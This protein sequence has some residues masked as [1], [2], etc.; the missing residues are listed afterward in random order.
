MINCIAV[1]FDITTLDYIT[2]LCS[3]IQFISLQ[4]TFNNPIE[5][6]R[7][8]R[9]HALDLIFINTS[10]QD[11][12]GFEFFKA[13]NQNLIVVFISE[14]KE[15]AVQAYDLNAVDYLLKPFASSRFNQCINKVQ[16][17]HTCRLQRANNEEQ[18]LHVRSEYSLIKIG[19][20][21]ILYIETLDDYIKIHLLGKKPV[22]T[23]MSMKTVMDKLPN[24]EF[25]RVHRSYIVPLNKIE[26]VRGK[27]ISLGIT[28]I[29]IGKSVEEAFFKAY[30]TKEF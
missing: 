3:D 24:S 9:K 22:L 21:E 13:L 1:D 5:A 18:F 30:I 20:Q 29:P 4:K 6:T 17:L 23:L 14:S 7:Y 19:L 16:E 25:V 15:D 11:L 26:S 8:A 2:T 28:E 12:T 27:V 10:L